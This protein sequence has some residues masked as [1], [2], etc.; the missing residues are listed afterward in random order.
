MKTWG[1]LAIYLV[2]V[3]VCSAL[4]A[5]WIYWLFQSVGT[6]G[7]ALELLGEIKFHD[8]LNRVLLITAL[9]GA[10]FLLKSQNALSR[11]TIGWAPSP[12][13]SSHLWLGASIA[14]ASVALAAAIGLATNALVWEGELTLA[15]FASETAT[16]LLAG[17]VV[18]LIEETWF[19]GCLLGWLRQRTNAFAALG[20]V[21]LFYAIVHFMDP[22]KSAKRIDV[23]WLSGFAMLGYYGQK[24]TEN[25][26]WLGQFILLVLIG[27]TLG[28]CFLKTSRL[29][30]SVGLHG[31][32]VFAGKMLT[33]LTQSNNLSD[34][35][36]FGRG[37]L[38]GSP[39]TIAV[40]AVVSGVIL[41]ICKRPQQ[42]NDSSAA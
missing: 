27:L 17:A 29:Y 15:T 13:A 3:I 11:E 7:S 33:F 42:R 40:V 9:I 21:T 16:N 5:P 32:W 8:V 10:Y 26:S 19:R 2:A 34:N 24:L 36:W 1:T 18:A 25:A 41:W 31:G 23:D 39:I 37:K 4:A 20:V 35:W 22:P 14:V 28:W 12:N 30:L 6:E 38:I